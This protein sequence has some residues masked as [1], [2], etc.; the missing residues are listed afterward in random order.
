GRRVVGF[1]TSSPPQP[2][3][4][5]LLRWRRRSHP[6]APARGEVAVDRP[7]PIVVARIGAD[8]LIDVARPAGGDDPD[9]RPGARPTLAPEGDAGGE[10]AVVR[11]AQVNL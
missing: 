8:A 5:V 7:H 2:P 11:P 4:R 1:F 3:S 10:V 9:A 6:I